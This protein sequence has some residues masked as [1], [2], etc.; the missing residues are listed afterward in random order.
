MPKL[1]CF[2][3]RED[4]IAVLVQRNDTYSVSSFFLMAENIVINSDELMVAEELLDKNVAVQ[5]ETKRATMAQKEEGRNSAA[6]AAIQKHFEGKV[7]LVLDY[8]VLVKSIVPLD[9]Q[10]DAGNLSEYNTMSA[11]KEPLERRTKYGVEYFG[12][13]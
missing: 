12:A 6:G 10:D 3:T 5:Q 13:P 2:K 8:K 1:A 9:G 4:W 7:L 11:Y